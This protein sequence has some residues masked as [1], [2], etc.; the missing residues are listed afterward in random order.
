[1]EGQDTS[2]HWVSV[3]T[4]TIVMQHERLA[5]FANRRAAAAACHGSCP[6]SSLSAHGSLG[7]STTTDRGGCPPSACPPLTEKLESFP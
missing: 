5:G 6:P 4:N 2:P 7:A 1:M 3:I